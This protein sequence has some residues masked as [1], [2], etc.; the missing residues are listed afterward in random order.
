MRKATFTYT[1]LSGPEDTGSPHTINLDQRSLLEGTTDR[2]SVSPA[3]FLIDGASYKIEFSGYDRA[4]NIGN[5][6]II[7]PVLYDIRKP[8]ITM[9][10]PEPDKVIIGQ[11]IS[12]SI[13]ENLEEGTISWVRS[14]G[15]REKFF[16]H[17]IKIAGVEKTQNGQL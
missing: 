2:Y 4:G 13:S 12:Y 15:D 16:T 5:V 6:V 1:W 10:I 14:G 7:E 9:T 11:E 8:I 17:T 3:P